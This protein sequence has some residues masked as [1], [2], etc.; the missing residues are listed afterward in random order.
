MKWATI[1]VGLAFL[2]LFVGAGR[3]EAQSTLGAP[4]I[5]TVGPGTG[6]LTVLWNAPSDNGGSDIVAYDL[7]HIPTADDETDDANWTVIEDVWVT[8]GGALSYQVLDLEDGIGFDVQVRAENGTDI[9]DWSSTSTGTTTDHGGTTAAAT[10]LTLGSSL[11]GRLGTATDEDVFEITLADDGEVWI[12]TTGLLDT[13]GELLDSGGTVLEEADDGTHLD[14]PLGFEFRETLDA[15]TYYIRISS[16]ED[17]AA[18]SYRIH[19]QTYTD[20]GDTFDTALDITL[21]SATPGRIDPARDKDFFKLVL[22]A[23]TDV[24]VMAYG[25]LEDDE[26]EVLDTVGTLYSG[27]RSQILRADDSEFVGNEEGFMFRRSLAAGTY[28]IRVSGFMNGDVGP[29]TLHVRTAAEPG[30]TAATATPLTLRIPETG[31]ITSSSDRD[32]FSLTLAED[33][34]VFIYALTF[35]SRQ[36]LTPTVLDDTNTEVS[37]HVVSNANW[38]EHGSG[39]ISF[40]VW[41]KLEAGTYRIRIG[42]STGNYLLDPLVSTYTRMLEECTAL[43]TPQSDPWYGCQWHLNNTDQFDDSAGEDINVE[44]VWTGGNMGEGINVAIV[45]DGLEAD[46]VDLVDNVVTSRNHDYTRQGGVYDPLQTH[47]TAVAGLVAARDNDI[48]VRGVA[49]RASIFAYNLVAR[50]TS[51]SAGETSAMY[52]AEDAAITAVSNNSWGSDPT[53]LPIASS[54][55]WQRAVTRGVNQGFG[56]KG[57]VYVLSAGNGHE[58]V[59]NDSNLDG[60]ANYYAVVAACAVGYDD[61][62]S[63]YSELGA[64]LWVCAPSN[65]GR[66][67]QGIT[68]THIPD[69]YRDN[70]GGTSAAAPIVSGVVALMRA[71]NTDLTW[72]DVKLVLAASARKNDASNTG[73]DEGALEY[74]STS[75][76]YNFNH[77][78]GFGVVDAAAAVALADGWTNVPSMR[79]SEVKSGRLGTDPGRS[80]PDDGTTVELT[81]SLDAYVSF[82][83]F[84]EITIDFR[85]DWFRDLQIELESPSGEVSILSVPALFVDGSPSFHRSY[86]FGSAKH[87][88]ESAEGT[89]TLKV[90]DKQTGDSGHITSWDLKVYGHGHN[91]GYVDIERVQP[92]P[93][94]ATVTWKEADEIGG[95]AVTSY[96]LRYKRHADSTWTEV[97]NIG[98]LDDRTHTVRD[99][100]QFVLYQFEVRAVNDDGAGPWSDSTGVYP[101]QVAPKPPLS[102]RAV[103]RDQS[104][105]VSW[106]E[107]SYT[108]AG[109]IVAYHIR[110]IEALATD[111]A[112]DKWTEIRDA[113]TTG[114]GEHRS[115]ISGLTNGTTYEVQVAAENYREES[116]WSSPGYGIPQDV[117]GPAEFPANESGQRSIPEN[118]PA[119]V[120]IGD[121]IAARDDEGDTRTYSLTSGAANFDIDSATGQL[122]TKTA[123]D[124]ERTASYS[125]TVAVHDG[126]ASDGTDSTSTDDTIRVTITVEDVDEPPVVSG[127]TTRTVRENATAV[128]TYSARDPERATT[129]FT[130]TLA[131]D[132][133]SA[134]A[135]SSS[136]VLTF[137][138]PPNFEA[139]ADQDGDDVY[140]VT[141]QATDDNATDPA[142]MTGELAVEVTVEDVDEPPEVSGAASYRINENSPTAVGA[143]T[144]SDPEGAD[145]TWESLGGSDA[146]HFEFDDL[147]GQLSFKAS[148]DFEARSDDTYE[149]QVRASDEGGRVGMLLVTITVVDVNEPPT[150]SGP[151]AVD[152]DEVPNPRSGQVVTVGT[153][154]RSDPERAA[155]NWAMR[156]QT[157]ALTGADADEFEFDKTNGRLRFKSPPNYE[158]QARFEV[159]LNA[160]DGV[161]DGDLDI[162]VTITNLEESGTLSLSGQLG[163]VNVPLRAT[164]VD[165]DGLVSSMW[166]WER[167]TSGSNSCTSGAWTEVTRNP[168][169]YTPTEDDLD[170]YLRATVTYEDGFDTGNTA[171]AVTSRVTAKRE[172]NEL[173][174]LPDLVDDIEIDE[175]TAPGRNVGSPVRATDE[176]GDPLE[177]T[178]SGASE[179]VIGETSGQIR[180]APGAILDFETPPTSYTVTVT[181]DDD[182]GGLDTVDVTINLRDVNEAPEAKDDSVVHDEDTSATVDVL[183]NDSDPED[184]TSDLTVSIQ[185]R[186]TNG[187]VAVNDPVNLGERPTITYTPNANYHGSDSFTYRVRDTGNLNS[188]VA[189]VALTITPVNDAP[190]FPAASVLRSEPGVS[191]SVERSVSESAGEGDNVGAPVTATDIEGDDVTYRLS[192]A[193]AFA[194]EIDDDGQITVG[195]GTTFDIATQATYSVTV[196]ATDSGNPP[197]SASIDVTITITTAPPPIIFTGGGGGGPTG[198]TPSEVD[199]EW[200]VK[201]DIEALDSGHDNPSGSW[202]DGA[203]LWLAENGDGADDAVYAY[204]LAT[205][206]RVEGREFPLDQR[207]RAPRGVASD[208]TTVWVADSGQDRLFAYDLATGERLEDRDIVLAEGNGDV[209]GIWSDGTTMWVLN[210]NPSL[211][212]YDLATGAL[213]GRFTLD[214]SNSDPNGIWSDGVTIWVSDPSSSPRRLF[215]YRVPALPAE[216]EAALE[217]PPALERVREEEF[218]DLS[219]ARNNSPRGIWSDGDVMYVADGSDGKVYTYNMPDAI[220][221]RLASLDLSGVEIGQFDPATTDYEG[222]PGEGVTQ[223]TVTAEAMQRRTEVTTDP[224]DADPETEGHQV[225][226]T[227]VGEITVT[228]TSQDG[229][230]TKVY[231]VALEQPPVELALAA[232]WTAIEWP[233]ADGA[234]LA[235]V[236]PEGVVAVY[237]WDDAAGTWL[238]YFPA[239][240]DVPG[241]NTLTTLSA[242]GTYWVAVEESVTWT[243]APAP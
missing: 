156:G 55:A 177:Y 155:T 47:G 169:A 208:G 153:Y 227:G 38:H 68:T 179:F 119:G 21:D 10:D 3:L 131:G 52:K 230:R 65:S 242:G 128:A 49:P 202:S 53:G 159:T 46:H 6:M 173:P 69:R 223:T 217:E 191:G 220:D 54:S 149:V 141:V 113:W 125:V 127:S 164:L 58:T 2:G 126:K 56:G 200:N 150:I 99:L 14:G 35:G 64:N 209:R 184:D 138:P 236:L 75:S 103:A 172:L 93:G 45:D 30:N 71:A 102:V 187:S 26:D 107:D 8:G 11:A 199:F 182:F 198:P 51:T 144:A 22:T 57:I 124:R 219:S 83:E 122:Q 15:G 135:I 32:Y 85:H 72:R 100:D 37:M 154:T 81:L 34:Y 160:N 162:V 24:W 88:G 84:V 238:A 181:A 36:A 210:R 39:E 134:F 178:L 61:K 97:T 137:D 221:A 243:V 76:R 183:A 226:L 136:G 234:A 70:F 132:D 231:R 130:W 20:P 29:Y 7:R 158:D 211:F 232:G 91:P 205:G 224:T 95:S 207:N 146:S 66:G 19:A 101:L 139:H 151:A 112:D 216:A 87:L 62:R 148:P 165:G 117:N 206:E 190:A 92:A 171:C 82:I 203:I 123:L 27:S 41:G 145:V 193:D 225:S 129:T 73:W 74:G 188:N 185:R 44:S 109:P 1:L 240:A 17:R 94:A 174:V 228:V 196:T 229:T 161:L 115:I 140:Q 78:Y 239:V 43:T 108:G 166:V 197:E 86:R 48:G 42:G 104:L 167:S 59:N 143:Y 180:V 157:A 110:Y 13:V 186:P 194:F 175:N 79:T 201:R 67:L 16:Y 90:T 60:R 116:W 98:T 96:D 176:D 222:V 33:L 25:T 89:W 80:I 204:D 215:A 28:Y 40:S 111:R 213:L 4:S 12:Y 195:A 147:T 212:A 214:G 142:A 106:Q 189:T 163:V 114:G 241:L 5:A 118:T 218:E 133:A 170:Q 9:G 235:E 63:D 168:G 50:G 23:T 152:I 105:P 77:E 120:D 121:P 192:G 233:G 18:G 237:A 31:R